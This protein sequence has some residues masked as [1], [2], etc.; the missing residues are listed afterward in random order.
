MVELDF[1]L[2]TNRN[3]LTRATIDKI[4][5]SVNLGLA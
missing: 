2:P 5:Y 4:D 3:Q 1:I